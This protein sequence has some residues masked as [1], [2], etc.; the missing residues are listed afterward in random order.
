MNI[1]QVTIFFNAFTSCLS[2]PNHRY[3]SWEHC[4][5]FFKGERASS[6]P[7]RYDL[8]SLHLAFYLASWGMM[9]GSSVLL[10][11]DYL[12]HVD[13]IKILWKSKYNS[14]WG[15]TWSSVVSDKSDI[16]LIF[17]KN[18]LKDELVSYYDR[19]HISPTDTLI[20]KIILGTMGCIPAYDRYLRTG[21]SADGIANISFRKKSLEDI[22]NSINSIT[23]YGKMSLPS[24]KAY[25]QMKIVDC[26]FWQFGYYIDEIKTQLKKSPSGIPVTNGSSSNTL[27]KS[28]G[29]YK[30]GATSY[31]SIKD[32]VLAGWYKI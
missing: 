11:K 9:R 10:Q 8:L 12:I 7:P 16:D 4:Y 19:Q 6:C 15:K 31:S 28:G 5:N 3:L 32:V 20:T 24:Y 25:P 17:N 30:V 13:A 29:S 14:L 1:S 23:S 26:V 2:T 21:L 22:I 27:S 18:G